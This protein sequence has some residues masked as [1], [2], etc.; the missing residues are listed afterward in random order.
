MVPDKNGEWKDALV[1][2]VKK[3]PS[4]RRI[5]LPPEERKPENCGWEE[6]EEEY[7]KRQ[8]EWLNKVG[9]GRMKKKK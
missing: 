1:E 8:A 6:T 9:K 3:M 2:M 4:V 5:V 7:L